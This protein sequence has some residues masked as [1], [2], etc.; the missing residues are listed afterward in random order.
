MAQKAASS[1]GSKKDLTPKWAIAM[2]EDCKQAASRAAKRQMETAGVSAAAELRSFQPAT[3]KEQIADELQA[4]QPAKDKEGNE[5]A[6]DFRKASEEG[7]DMRSAIGAR[8]QKALKA[9]EKLRKDYE[10][11]GKKYAMQREF[12]KAWAAQ[13]FKKATMPDDD[14]DWYYLDSKNYKTAQEFG[15]FSSATMREWYKQGCFTVGEDFMFRMPNWPAH[16]PLE[17]IWLD[18]ANDAFVKA[19]D[20]AGLL[21]LHQKH[22]QHQRKVARDWYRQVEDSQR[23]KAKAAETLPPQPDDGSVPVLIRDRHGGGWHRAMVRP[24]RELGPRPT[25]D[26]GRR[27]HGQ[28]AA[29]DGATTK[30]PTA[31]EKEQIADE[32]QT[33]QPATEKE[34]IA[35]KLQALQPA[36][37]KEQFADELQALQPATEKE[38]SAGELQAL[39]PAMAM[40]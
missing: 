18:V 9:S 36:T 35:D 6:D 24:I 25:C 4:L 2:A 37:E 20:D 8:W 27:G 26:S 32:L 13:E 21:K 10:A 33:M 38:P 5:L 31:T 14:S 16:R 22:M 29:G 12:R 19:P 17:E 34:Q 11:C 30:P 28:L 40:P 1:R 15:P 23:A 39:Q 7:F 3:E